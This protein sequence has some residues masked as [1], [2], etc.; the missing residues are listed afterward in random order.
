MLNHIKVYWI[1]NISVFCC[2]ECS[3]SRLSD[4]LEQSMLNLRKRRNNKTFHFPIMLTA[5]NGSHTKSLKLLTG[6]KRLRSTR[7]KQQHL[8]NLYLAIRARKTINQ[9][10]KSLFVWKESCIFRTRLF[11]V[12]F[13]EKMNCFTWLHK[14]AQKRLPL[15]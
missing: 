1:Q 13:H 15:L 11:V 10:S 2:C 14:Y 4:W 7:R 9:L 6:H 3:K 5:S 8:A 12:T